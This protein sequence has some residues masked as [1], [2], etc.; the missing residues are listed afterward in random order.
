MAVC[1]FSSS[2]NPPSLPLF[3][4]EIKTSFPLIQ[5]L[6]CFEPS[7]TPRSIKLTHALSPCMNKQHPSQH[8]K[9]F[10]LNW[11]NTEIDLQ[12]VLPLGL[13]GNTKR[14]FSFLFFPCFSINGVGFRIW[15]WKSTITVGVSQK[16]L[17]FY[18][19]FEVPFKGF[20]REIWRERKITDAFRRQKQKRLLALPGSDKVVFFILFFLQK[21]KKLKWADLQERDVN[22][23]N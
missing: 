16:G 5:S 1:F 3:V 12:R 10:A 7:C 14:L 8:S 2:P 23:Y 15:S 6:P 13:R 17:F 19:I 4:V 9:S 11:I 20:D 18:F 21:W 22:L